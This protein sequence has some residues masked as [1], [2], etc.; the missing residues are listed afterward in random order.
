MTPIF[1]GSVI[2]SLSTVIPSAATTLTLA[3]IRCQ[4]CHRLLLKWSPR[5]VMSIE[6]KCPRCGRIDIL[7]LSTA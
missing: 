1:T 7:R 5:G 6:V 4:D 3:E 2:R